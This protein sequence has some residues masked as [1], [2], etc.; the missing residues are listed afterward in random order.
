MHTA[1]CDVKED[2]NFRDDASIHSRPLQYTTQAI[3]Q[4]WLEHESC[5][6]GNDCLDYAPFDQRQA[7]RT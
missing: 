5:F 7:Q 4:K 2:A 3:L 6:G 1:G